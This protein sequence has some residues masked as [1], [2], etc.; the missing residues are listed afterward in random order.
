MDHATW[1]SYTCEY[2]LVFSR[3]QIGDIK[4]MRLSR[5]TQYTRMAGK[6]KTPGARATVS[7]QFLCSLKSR[8][9]HKG[10]VTFAVYAVY[11]DGRQSQNTGGEGDRFLPEISQR[12]PRDFPEVS[13]PFPK[14]LCRG[15]AIVFPRMGRWEWP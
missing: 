11:Q 5:C 15:K 1:P 12:F 2:L 13:Q 9:G 6:V 14:L 7:C 4:S 3:S 10:D 8:R